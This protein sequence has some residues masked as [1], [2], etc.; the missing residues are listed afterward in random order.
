M[1]LLRPSEFH[2][3]VLLVRLPNHDE[4]NTALQRI[5]DTGLTACFK[6]IGDGWRADG[7]E[8]SENGTPLY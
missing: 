6:L 1:T 7:K 2:V 3:K 5:Q 8:A 4:L